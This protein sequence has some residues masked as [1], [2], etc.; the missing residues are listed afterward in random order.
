MP[1]SRDEWRQGFVRYLPREQPRASL[2]FW[3]GVHHIARR[4]RDGQST[5]RQWFR[6]SSGGDALA[7][8]ASV[9]AMLLTAVIERV[10]VI[11]EQPT[12][13]GLVSRM[14]RFMPWTTEA[15]MVAKPLFVVFLFAGL[16]LWF[17]LCLPSHGYLAALVAAIALGCG[18]CLRD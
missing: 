18:V 10:L 15:N 1:S 4:P 12:I 11:Y 3:G 9:L 13:R 7:P 5:R 6:L 16:G 17:V 8:S 14:S 2:R